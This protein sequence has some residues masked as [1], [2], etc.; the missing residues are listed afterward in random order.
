MDYSQYIRLK[1]EAANIYLARNKPIDSSFLTMQKQQKAAY[2][3]SSRFK[4]SPY[5]KGNPTL[6]PILYDISSCPI[7]HAF[8]QGYTNTVN[9]S[10]QEGIAS[11]RAGAILCCGPDYSKV[12]PVMVLINQNTCSTIRTSYNNNQMVPSVFQPNPEFYTYTSPVDIPS[13]HFGGSSFLQLSIDNVYSGNNDFTI[14]FYVRP[15]SSPSPVQTIFF[16]GKQSIADTYKFIGNLVS[17]I[18]GKKYTMSVQI[19]TLGST[20]FGDLYPDKWYHVAVMR[21]G[22]VMY[23]YLNGYLITYQNLPGNIPASGSPGF[24]N[25]LSG[26]ES[27]LT[28]GGKYDGTVRAGSTVALADTFTGN[29]ANFIW[30]KGKAFYTKPI[31]VPAVHT[32]LNNFKTPSIPKFIH[33]ASNVSTLSYPYVSVGLLAESESSIIYNTRTPTA[34][35][36]STDGNTVNPSLYASLIWEKI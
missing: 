30:T 34:T 7:D 3:G 20:T 36:S 17:T 28:I 2:S 35:V 5:F 24:T 23:F 15:S 14:E 6:N 12:P 25:Y 10:Q 29:I 8:T 4:I 31:G 19:S 13:M 21:F 22:N 18:P 11:E 27:A 16:I 32:L 1:Q 33:S 26:G 9:L